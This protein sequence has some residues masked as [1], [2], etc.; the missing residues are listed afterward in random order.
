[1]RIVRQLD[2]KR[3]AKG[4]R[5]SRDN[6]KSHDGYVPGYNICMIVFMCPASVRCMVE[7]TEPGFRY[8]VGA[9]HVEHEMTHAKTLHACTNRDGHDQVH[10]AADW[11]AVSH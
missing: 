2:R 5:R 3:N 6:R 10:V 8:G 9:V 4:A 7:Y 11:R 1:M